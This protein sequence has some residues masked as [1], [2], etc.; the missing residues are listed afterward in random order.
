MHDSRNKPREEITVLQC[1]DGRGACSPFF[2]GI[3]SK[4]LSRIWLSLSL[5][6]CRLSSGVHSCLVT[7][8]LSST[9]LSFSQPSLETA[10]LSGS[11]RLRISFE[12]CSWL[13]STSSMSGRGSSSWFRSLICGFERS[14]F[15]DDLAGRERC[16][17]H[18]FG[19]TWQEGQL[20]MSQQ[21]Q[22]WSG[23]RI[24][25]GLEPIIQ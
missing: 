13:A 4:R 6:I 2:P 15:Q 24:F 23:L 10:S 9:F 21:P 1:T 25:Y 14:V 7:E 11:S 17:N 19:H 16:K 18:S 12:A 8:L 22:L 3:F 5:W 20:S